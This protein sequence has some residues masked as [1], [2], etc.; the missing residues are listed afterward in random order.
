MK[1]TVVRKL[2]APACMALAL[3]ALSPAAHAAAPKEGKW[4]IG[5]YAGTYKPESDDLEDQDTFGVRLGYMFTK[6]VSFGGSLG[7]ISTESDISGTGVSGEV[8]IDFTLLDFDF[9]YAFRPD[10]RFSIALGGGP[11]WAFASADGEVTTPLGTVSFE[12]ADDD[13]FTMNAIVGG[14]IGLGK[15]RKFFLRPATRFRWFEK[16]EEDDID[17][18]FTVMFGWALGK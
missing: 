3:A 15:T 4:A 7:L 14:A 11:G 1:I 16:R 5:F 12:G 18:E 17:Q 8:D 6:H 9:V 13:S 2:V 10:K